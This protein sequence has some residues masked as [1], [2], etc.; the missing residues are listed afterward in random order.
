MGEQQDTE[1][2]CQADAAFGGGDIP[3]LLDLLD[4]DIEWQ[5]VIGAAPHVPTAGTRYGKQAVA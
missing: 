4:D 2:V 3:A 5:A 1:I